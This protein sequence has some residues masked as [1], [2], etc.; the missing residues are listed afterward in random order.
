MTDRILRLSGA[1][2]GLPAGLPP[3]RTLALVVMAAALLL[4]PPVAHAIDAPFY[5]TL[6]SRVLVFALAAMSLD[7]ILGYGGMVSL[8]HAAFVGV[9]AYTVAILAFH[10]D[11]GSALLGLIPG[12]YSGWIAWPAA[13]LVSGALA[14]LIGLVSLRTKGVHFIMITLAFAQ[15]VYFLFVSVR[16]YGGDDGLSL[17]GRSSFSG[18]VNLRDK[19]SFYYV[20]LGLLAVVGYLL[21][22]LTR[23]RFGMVLRGAKVNERRMTHIGFPVFRYRLVAFT[24]AGA[25]AGLAGALL[26]NQSG[27]VSPGAMHWSHSG[28]IIIMVVLGGMGSLAGPVV[29]AFVFLLMEEVLSG[30]TEHW[31]VVFGP[32]LVLAV[33]YARQG[34]FGAAP[35]TRAKIPPAKTSPAETP[36]V[37]P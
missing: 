25:I 33:M 12:T 22:R 20:A 18:L 24:L 7:L 1:F 4:L 3:L 23:S 2:P 31:Q 21:W 35:I 37:T 6:V 32:V 9:G 29:G 5:V 36:E 15:M 14:F 17:M 28:E 26:A 30:F 13:M 8:G 16:T 11:D 27:Y 34:L 10:V 19:T